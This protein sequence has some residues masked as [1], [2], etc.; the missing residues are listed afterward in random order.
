MVHELEPAINVLCTVSC[1]VLVSN[2]FLAN[3]F[4]YIFPLN[5]ARYGKALTSA[6]WVQV[7]IYIYIY[8]YRLV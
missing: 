6:L 1:E 8:I 7:Y 5:M 4:Q 2:I 3:I